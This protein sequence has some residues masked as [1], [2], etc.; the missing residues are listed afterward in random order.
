MAGAGVEAGRQLRTDGDQISVG[1]APAAGCNM[2]GGY[3][4]C[5]RGHANWVSPEAPAPS[6]ESCSHPCWRLVIY[7]SSPRGHRPE[8][9]NCAQAAACMGK[10]LASEAPARQRTLCSIEGHQA[11]VRAH[12]TERYWQAFICSCLQSHIACTVPLHESMGS[13]LPSSSPRRL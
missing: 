9:F 1:Q 4:S 10:L 5:V 3:A 12:R 8:H 2:C 11:W 7:K 13:T 6:G